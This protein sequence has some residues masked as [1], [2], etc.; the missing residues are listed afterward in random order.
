MASVLSKVGH[1]DRISII[2]HLDEL[3][4]RLVTCVVTLGVAFALCFWQNAALLKILNQPLKEAGTPNGL[5]TGA[6]SSTPE[7]AGVDSGAEAVAGAAAF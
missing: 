6:I 2:D 7:E 1:E 4:S 5:A 3:R